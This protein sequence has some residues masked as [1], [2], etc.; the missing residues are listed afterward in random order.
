MTEAHTF[1]PDWV[2]PPGDTIADLLEERGWTQVEL[3][4]RLDF[5]TKHI[6]LLINGKAPIAEETA[7]K[8]ER[9]LGGDIGFWLSREAQY[10][11]QLT[12][13]SEVQRL[14]SWANWL[15]KLPVRDLMKSGALTKRRISAESKPD[16]VQD[17][18][19]F[20]GVSSPDAWVQHYEMMECAF[21]RTRTEQS[22]IGA[23]SAWLRMGETQAEKIN[24]PKYDKTRFEAALREIRALTV[25]E[26]QD[27]EPKLRRL[28]AE[29]G[30]AFVLVPAI[31]GAHVSGVA[32]WLGGNKPLI[33]LSLYGK[34]N[35]KFWFTFFHEA[36]HLLLHGRTEVFLDDISGKGIDSKEEREA[37]DW[38]GRF[39][40]PDEF[41]SELPE[42][43]SRDAATRLANR[44]GI[45][46]GIV[47]G[48]LQHDKHIDVRW[49]NNLKVSFR[50]SESES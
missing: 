18:L 39:L 2:S 35:D 8:L 36:A 4:Q 50:F 33:Q 17:M 47:V 49:L 27:F 26:P 7:L 14:A 11:E 5:T 21:R 13:R 34:A 24:L 31:P 32:R 48:R 29:S 30:V 28:C 1:T 22:D 6:S 42:A 25:R 37:N 38:A 10:R 16:I 12:R 15:D 19:R 3:A 43:R 40:I 44:I 23:I 45:H 9:V 41:V 46:P 20:F